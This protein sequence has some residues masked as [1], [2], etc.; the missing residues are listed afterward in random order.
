MHNQFTVTLFFFDGFSTT[1]DL[2][3]RAELNKYL[4][5]GF[6]MDHVRSVQIIHHPHPES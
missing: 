1:R 5:E 3:D 6:A 4:L 2:M